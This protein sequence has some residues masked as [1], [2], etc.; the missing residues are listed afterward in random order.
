MR[1]R[2]AACTAQSFDN[3]LPEHH[4][5]LH[6]YGTSD[7]LEAPRIAGGRTTLSETPFARTKT[8]SVTSLH[9]L[10]EIR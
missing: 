2:T 5:L 10:L 7:S 4:R 9:V 6:A 3:P 8:G 1:R